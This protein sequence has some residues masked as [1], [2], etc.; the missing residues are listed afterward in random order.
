MSMSEALVRLHAHGQSTWLDFIRRAFIDSGQLQRLIDDGW[1]SGLT[2]NPTIFAKAISGS[3][4]YDEELRAI[5]ASG[6]DDPY[7]AFVQLASAD[8]GRAADALRPIYDSSGGADGYVSFELPP[9]VE[10]D[11]AGSIAEAKRLVEAVGRPN[12]MIKVPGTAAAPAS[13]EQLIAD[14]VNVNI[15]LLFDVAV[16]ERVARA[17]IAGLERAREAGRDLSTI[18]SV[19]SFFVSR[20][21]TAADRELPEG[22]PL[23]GRTGVANARVASRRFG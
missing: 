16:Y 6:G 19:A 23:R 21:D 20:V 13:V 17:Y 8:L 15:T 9:G 2:S 14:G 4:D 12:V 18:A 5:A 10:H 1:I 11:S 3:T 7:E 22:S